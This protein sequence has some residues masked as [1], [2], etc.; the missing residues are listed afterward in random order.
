MVY[1]GLKEELGLVDPVWS[2][3][4]SEWR[5]LCTLWLRVESA[6]GKTGRPDLT[7]QEIGDLIVPPDIIA[8][9]LGNKLAEDHPLPDGGFGAIWT[10]FL[11]GLPTSEW[12]KSIDIIKEM[13]CR[14]GPTGIVFFL[15]GTYWQAEYSGTGKG[16]YTNVK[17]IEHIFNIILDNPALYVVVLSCQII[18]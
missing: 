17:R 1:S 16:W 3:Q 9:M 6:L 4:P 15:L 12:G 5:S 11:S 13:W 8:W 2:A 7:I 18:F 14:P 10:T